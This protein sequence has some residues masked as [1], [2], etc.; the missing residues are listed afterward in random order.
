[1]SVLTGATVITL[2]E[3]PNRLA[4]FMVEWERAAIPNL[5]LTVATDHLDVDP[6]RGCW[7]AHVA[8]LVASTGPTLLLED[9]VIF[10]PD[11]THE[12]DYPDDW[13]IMYFGG[14]FP[15]RPP[16]AAPV[17]QVW[18]SGMTHGY[19]VKDP[20]HVAEL[21]GPYKKGR[22]VGAMLCRLKVMKYAVNP[23]TIGQGGGRESTINGRIR[24]SDDFFERRD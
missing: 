17:H 19:A 18:R 9:D 13:E 6:V 8:A 12:I 23:N 21:L 7:S 3:T 16:D 14:Y 2:E 20:Q 24:Q 15:R 5:P 4:G 1:M 10:H 22:N 11:F